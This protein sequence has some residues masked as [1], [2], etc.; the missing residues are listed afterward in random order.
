[1]LFVF[2]AFLAH[3]SW[4]IFL[5]MYGISVMF[6]SLF[7]LLV[8]RHQPNYSYAGASAAVYAMGFGAIVLSPGAR[9]LLFGLLPVP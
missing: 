8:Y 4:L 6:S 7:A 2:A 9:L 1:G 3:L 5:S